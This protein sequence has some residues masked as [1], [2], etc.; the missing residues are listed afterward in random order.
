M[1]GFFCHFHKLAESGLVRSGQMS[2]QL[3]VHFDSGGLQSFYEAAVTQSGRARRR[4]DANLPKSAKRA[5][6]IFSISIGILAPVIQGVGGISIK[7]GTTKAKALGGPQCPPAAL[8]RSGRIGY[9]HVLCLLGFRRARLLPNATAKRQI[10]KNAT[11]IG[12][13]QHSGGSQPPPLFRPLATQ[14]VP[15]AGAIADHFPG[16]RNFE[17]FG[18]RLPCFLIS[19]ASHNLPFPSKE[20]RV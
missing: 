17:T 20:W 5:F 4:V 13:I 3:A 11:L 10:K 14:Q 19:S 12:R 7:F 18:N 2:Q 8:S 9:S 6:L 16:R 1:E 15:L